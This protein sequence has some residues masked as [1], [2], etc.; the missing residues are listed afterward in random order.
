M[1]CQVNLLNCHRPHLQAEACA[2]GRAMIC[3]PG[4]RPSGRICRLKPALRAGPWSAVLERGLQAASAGWSLHSGPGHDLLSWS[5]AFR[6]HL[7]AEACA[8]GRA[9][10]LLSWSAAFRPHLQ[11]E[12]C[13]PGRAMICCPGVRPSGRI[14]R[15]KPALR[16]G[17]LSASTEWAV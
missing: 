13:T 3:C 9:H 16:A 1:D 6:P 8:P 7:Q 4:A 14:C 11:A 2:P 5:A 17:P 12:A 15:L 10:D